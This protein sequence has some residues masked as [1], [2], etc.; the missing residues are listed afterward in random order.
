MSDQ[1][2]PTPEITLG[3]SP[4][5]DSGATATAMPEYKPGRLDKKQN[6]GAYVGL[7]R[8][9]SS[10]ARVR[11][12]PGSGKIT[13]NKRDLEKFFAKEQDRENVVKPLEAT[14]NRNQFDLYVTVAGGGTTGQSGAI[15][16]GV[17]RALVRTNREHLSTL[18]DKGYLTRD[19]REVERKKPGQ[20][21]ARKRFQFS[22]R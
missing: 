12:R 1:P 9:K 11:L 18:R 15:L 4:A 16:L 17:A 21:K 10:V 8:R 3:D 22:K 6:D 5:A 2:T 14:G 20:K 13:I 7:G 19:P